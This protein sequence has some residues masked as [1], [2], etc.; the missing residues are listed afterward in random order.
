MGPTGGDTGGARRGTVTV[1]STATPRR[2]YLHVGA[3]KTGTTYLQGVL[4]ANRDRLRDAGVLV[5]GERFVDQ[6]AAV[7]DLLGIQV[8]PREQHP[9]RLSWSQLVGQVRDWRGAAAVV[10]M[11]FLSFADRRQA[12]RAV[13]SLEPAEVHVVLTARDLARMVPA[14]WQEELKSRQTWTWREYVD[15]VR[16]PDAAT[17]PPARQF[18]RAQDLTGVL[19]SWASA[20]P[21]ERIHVVTVP[22][23]GAPA[24]LLLERFASVLGIDATGLRPD[25]S[26]RNESLGIAEAEVLRRLNAGLDGRLTKRQ[27]DRAVKLGVARWLADRSDAVRIA[28]PPEELGWVQE[29]S[30]STVDALRGR[31]YDVRGDLADLLPDGPVS[32]SARHPDSATDAELLDAAMHALVELAARYGEQAPGKRADGRSPAGSAGLRTRARS[33]EYKLKQTAMHLADRNGALGRVRDA[34]LRRW[35]R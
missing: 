15:A 34:Y 29:R 32:E 2:V 4:W 30:R 6:V 7:Q 11:E 24:E 17:R 33:A 31:G 10:S 35:S 3:L 26:R 19:D 16:D 21:P 18:W 8:G 1:M 5:P 12:R 20:V 13:R 25:P 23:P 22:P 27:Y 9:G 28:L 14:R